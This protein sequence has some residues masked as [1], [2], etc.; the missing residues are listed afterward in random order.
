MRES[1]L[2]TSK[3]C[4][5][6]AL[7]NSETAASRIRSYVAAA[8]AAARELGAGDGGDRRPVN[9]VRPALPKS[10]GKLR[11][12]CKHHIGAFLMA[13]ILVRQR[14]DQRPLLASVSQA[15]QMLA[16]FDTRAARGDGL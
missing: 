6:C 3:A 9:G 8:G 11:A 13:A 12:A 10:V 5:T 14:T 7:V 4:R 15:R 1:A 16:N 2:R